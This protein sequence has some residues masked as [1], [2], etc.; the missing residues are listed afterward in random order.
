VEADRVLTVE[1]LPAKYGDALLVTWGTGHTLHHLLIDGG[2]G[3]AYPVVSARLKA[4]DGDLE[5]LVVTHVDVDHI[6]GAVRLLDNAAL[7]RCF[8]QVWFNGFHH[9]E[10][11]N[12]LLG[13]LD[14]E[15]LSALIVE[16]GVPWNVGWP[17]PV[18]EAIGGPVVVR[19]APPVVDLAGGATLTVLSP[20][21]PKMKA[22]LKV[23]TEVIRAAG[24]VPGVRPTRDPV[25]P[26]RGLLG[27][28]LDDLAGATVADDDAEANGSSIAFVF[29]FAG[30]RVLFGADAHPDALLAGLAQLTAPG[31]RYRVDACKLPHH[32]SRR[33]VTKALIQKLDCCEWWFSSNGVRFNHPNHEA[34]ARVI[35][36]G[37]A[38]PR[39]AGN[40]RSARWATFTADFPPAQFG[41]ELTL[42]EPGTEGLTFTLA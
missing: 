14:G 36:F 40:Y 4:L 35:R 13:P 38:P 24:L 18:S 31:E 42:P 10:Q 33:N 3:S 22:M 8:K 1:M 20:T 34:V 9:F 15:R 12:D 19:D 29:E 32:G 39:L 16:R 7:A 41:Y 28:T 26:G 5:L 17:N 6:A 27:A 37:S 30:K 21:P 2:L 11:F 23:W 25:A